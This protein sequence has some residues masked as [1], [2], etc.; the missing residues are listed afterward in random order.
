MRAQGGP[1][2]V[3]GNLL[4]IFHHVVHRGDHFFVGTAHAA[5]LGDH[6]GSGNTVNAAVM[7]RLHALGDAVCPGY[8]VTCYGG[9][10]GASHV[11]CHACSVVDLFTRTGGRHGP[12]CCRTGT[13]GV[14]VQADFTHRLDTR[15]DIGPL[16]VCQFNG[17][18]RHGDAQCCYSQCNSADHNSILTI[19][20]AHY[21]QFL[22]GGKLVLISAGGGPGF[23]FTI[24]RRT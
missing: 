4:A 17:T 2:T 15:L 10:A 3:A 8:Q 23:T 9:T 19:W 1:S 18:C 21:S 11:A 13:A 24:H 5:A 16:L 12:W 7:K 20:V 22:P 14:S 6:A